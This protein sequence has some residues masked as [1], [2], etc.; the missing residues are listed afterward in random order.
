MS[1]REAIRVDLLTI[2]TPPRRKLPAR[3]TRSKKGGAIEATRVD[4]STIN[5][6]R[7]NSVCV[8]VCVCV[9]ERERE[10]ERKKEKERERKRNE[11]ARES[12]HRIVS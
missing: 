5:A 1:A 3:V 11:E 10:R 4:F 7:E 9:K 8:C 6:L 2:K 12:K